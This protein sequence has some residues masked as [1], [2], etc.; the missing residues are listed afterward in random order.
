MELLQGRSKL[1]AKKYE[2]RR[3]ILI[4]SCHLVLFISVHNFMPTSVQYRRSWFKIKLSQFSLFLFR[5][6]AFCCEVRSWPAFLRD[7]NFANRSAI[8]SES[9]TQL[10]D[11]WIVFALL[12]PASSILPIIFTK[13]L[14]ARRIPSL[15]AWFYR[16]H[17]TFSLCVV[18]CIS[19]PFRSWFDL[20]QKEVAMELTLTYLRHA[21][22]Q[23]KRHYTCMTSIDFHSRYLERTRKGHTWHRRCLWQVSMP[24]KKRKDVG[25]CK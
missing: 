9:F 23:K 3:W 25:V 7:K 24:L 14:F 21:P 16:F 12:F 4:S 8:L 10:T 13:P 17:Y 11:R 1:V 6:F 18:V 22:C 5:S 15:S 2:E 20:F 19:P